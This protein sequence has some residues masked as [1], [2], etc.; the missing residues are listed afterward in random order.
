ML[1][2]TLTLFTGII[3][4][5][6]GILFL[7]RNQKL[8]QKIQDF[9]RSKILSIIFMSTGCAWFLYRHVFQLSEADFGDYK[10]IISLVTLFIFF[11]SFIFTSDFLAVRGLSIVI[12]LYAREVLDAAF[13][14]E[15]TSRLVHVSVIYLFIILALYFGAWPYRMRDSLNYLFEKPRRAS[16][17]GLSSVLTAVSIFISAFFL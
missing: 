11:S 5:V 14:Q 13:L 9:P 4:F 17:L 2:L 15:P 1:L 8:T 7:V 6:A 10:L 16:V 12:L 3:L